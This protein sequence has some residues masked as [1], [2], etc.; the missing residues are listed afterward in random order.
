[1]SAG[2]LFLLVTLVSAPYV[3]WCVARYMASYRFEVACSGHLKRAADANTVE[4][5][6][7]ELDIAVAYL[8]E[9]KLTEGNTAIILPTPAYDIGFFY[10]NLKASLGELEAVKPDAT[11]L[12]KSNVLIKLRETLLDHGEGIY[13]TLP[14][15]IS[16]YPYH[17][18][19]FWFSWVAGIVGAIGW[20]VFFLELENC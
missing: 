14:P 10:K 18:L 11:Q 5:A 20:I 6:K 16:I 19:Q 7:E 12:E 2:K 3:S 13:I 9:R 8:E 17:V 4:L 1:M 15:R